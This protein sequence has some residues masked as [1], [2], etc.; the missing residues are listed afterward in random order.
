MNKNTLIIIAVILLLP[1]LGNQWLLAQPLT[2][3]YGD[4]K[5]IHECRIVSVSEF[6]VSIEYTPFLPGIYSRM[7]LSLDS[8]T[9]IREFSRANKYVP[10]LTFLGS[11]IGVRYFFK[12]RDPIDEMNWSERVAS[13]LDT[14]L[15]F[16]S[17][18]CVGGAVGY[19]GGHYLLGGNRKLL[20]VK[21]MSNS[22]KQI[23]LSKYIEPIRHP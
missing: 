20:V 6:N 13:W 9:G 18:V 2:V 3:F 7:N 11:Y 15:N 21:D 8:I 19:L 1:L 22:E 23:L 17:S 10:Y 14:P 12:E 16:M 4:D 5:T